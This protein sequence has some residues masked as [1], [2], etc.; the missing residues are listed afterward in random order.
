MHTKILQYLQAATANKKILF[1]SI[2]GIIALTT[3]GIAL[4]A[5]SDDSQDL[6]NTAQLH[7]GIAEVEVAVAGNISDS[8][9]PGTKSSWPGELVSL[10]NVPIQPP[11]EGTIASWNVHI[12]QRVVQGEILGTLSLP[13]Q[14]PD[15]IAM[16]ADEQKMVSMARVS[17]ESKRV[18]IKGRI[19]QLEELRANT[20]L[21]LRKSQSLLGGSTGSLGAQSP[22]ITM[23]E[24]KKETLRAMLRGTLAKTYSML[25]GDGTL[26]SRWTAVNLKDA[27]GAQNTS[28]RYAFPTTLFAAL[29]DI[30]EREKLPIASGLAY[31]EL[32][33]KLAD[34]SIPDGAMLTDAELTN[35]KTMLHAD[36]EAFIM[37]VDKLR[38]TELEAVDKEKMSFEQLRM[39]DNDI[40]MLQTDLAMSEG[41]LASKEAAYQTIKNGVLGNSAIIAPRSGT[42]SSLTKKIGEFVGPGMPVAVVTG[43]KANDYIVRF[44]IP[45]NVQKPRIGDE[46]YVTRPGFPETMPRAKLIGVGNSLDETGSIVADA[47]LLE[48]TD[49]PVGLS[50]RVLSASSSDAI[51]IALGSVW[52]DAT[53]VPS[54]WAVSDAGR[55]YAKKIT[56]G[57]TL[58][59]KVEI[60]SGLSRGD[61]YIVKPVPSITENMLVGDILPTHANEGGDV[62]PAKK[63]G[64]EGMPGMEM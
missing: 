32:T 57:R 23:I 2:A 63:T 11:R 8:D 14:M 19:T 4:S 53:G 46:F 38:E 61:H 1:G 50:L 37:A 48:P 30:N 44:R 22:D 16:L 17:T 49:W 47:L 51:E 18:Y 33:I 60:Y 56:L 13:P 58:G 12:G 64:H 36:Q 34:A 5:W 43:G 10:G 52:W 42:I 41:D 3:G 7:S 9:I 29:N 21:S 54:V 35:L 40:A 15:N 62:V 31:F 24:A 27:V 45:S 39:I 26:P 28:L 55:I 20:E 25:S 6:A 59:D